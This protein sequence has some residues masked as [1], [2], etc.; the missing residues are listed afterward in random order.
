MTDVISVQS[1]DNPLLVRLRRQVQDGAAYRR[2]GLV[3]LEGEHLC[4]AVQQRGWPVA[5]A[6]LSHRAQQYAHLFDLACHAARV[7]LVPDALFADISTL[8]S[9]AGIGFVLALP[10][11]PLQPMLGQ[12]AVILD[13]LQ[14]PGNVGQILRTAAALGVPQVLALK[15]TVALWSPKVLRAAMGAH[16]GLRLVEG[17]A[18]QPL[19]ALGTP[20]VATSSHGGVP[21][22][23]AQLPQPA[24][25]VF[26]H[27]GQGVD[28]AVAAMCRMHVA[29]PQPGGE[30]SL[31]VAA[32][33]AICLY[34]AVR[35]R[36]A[37]TGTQDQ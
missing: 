28:P 15:G 32:A 24:A 33:A 8:E 29:I 19:A 22:T 16:L 1:R 4:Q 7:V 30:E 13:R 5:Q 6:V 34:E 37:N 3:W 2:D 9:P 20:L 36:Q 23:Q 18:P 26:G 25:W 10:E 12:G 11:L 21:L 17:L 31:N 35:Q 14:D 27:E